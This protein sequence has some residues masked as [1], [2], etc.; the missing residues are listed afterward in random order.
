[1]TRRPKIFCIGFHKTGTTSLYAALSSLGLKVSGTI[2]HR[3]SAE[4]LRREGA[5]LCIR[6]A[7]RFDAAEDMPWPTF[8]RELDDAYPDSK[9]ILTVREPEAWFASIDRHFGDVDTEMHR[10]IYGPH[11][12]RARD[13]RAHWI[14]TMSAHN[15]AVRAHFTGRSEQ[16]LEMNLAKGDGW[17]ML[18]P[19]LGVDRPPAPF[20]VKNTSAGRTRLSYRVKKKLNELVG[21]AALPERLI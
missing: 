8:F 16:L 13:D 4:R 1:M 7:R 19:F 21:R 6:T 5:A 18:A 2:G 15:A 17:E 20:P 10:F 12:G 14:A 3:W 11:K 9:F